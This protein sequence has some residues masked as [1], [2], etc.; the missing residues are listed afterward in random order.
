VRPLVSQIEFEA[1][2]IELLKSPCTIQYLNALPSNH[3][4]YYEP[5]R[6]PDLDTVRTSSPCNTD[7]RPRI[8]SQSTT[9]THPSTDPPFPSYSVLDPAAV[10]VFEPSLLPVTSLLEAGRLTSGQATIVVL[11]E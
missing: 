5:A 10:D 7:R 6:N 2:E 4:R 9:L 11:E 1:H 3:H 8:V